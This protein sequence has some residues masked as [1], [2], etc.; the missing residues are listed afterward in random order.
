MMLTARCRSCG[1][2]LATFAK[3]HTLT[4]VCRRC[5]ATNIFNSAAAEPPTDSPKFKKVYCQCG[6]VLY[7][8]ESGVKTVTVAGRAA[9]V[10]CRRCKEYKMVQ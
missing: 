7:E 6:K 3:A 8:V 10:M 4:L 2:K 1:A 5:K 9:R